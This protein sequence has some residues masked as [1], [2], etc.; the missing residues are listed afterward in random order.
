MG[1]QLLGEV[2]GGK[3]IQSQIQEIGF[4]D[5]K[6]STD[7][8]KDKVFHNFPKTFKAFQ[9]HSY[10]ISGLK[11]QNIK[12]LAYTS[13]TP[14]QLFKYK[15]HAYGI[16]FHLEIK[17]DTIS[18]W[19]TNKIYK[20]SLIDKFGDNAIKYLEKEQKLYLDNINLLCSK[21]FKNINIDNS[22]V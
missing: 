17:S 6:L 21:L 4:C 15:N 20:D 18:N 12:I 3:V 10:E 16:Q 1:C 19:L 2:L 13:T 8:K 9:W 22:L 5:V 7:G 11:N 14:I